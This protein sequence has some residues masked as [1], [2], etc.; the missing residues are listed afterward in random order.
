[1][2]T[3]NNRDN[4]CSRNSITAAAE[5]R[6]NNSRGD[7]SN[8]APGPS[9][10]CGGAPVIVGVPIFLFKAIYRGVSAYQMRRRDVGH[11]QL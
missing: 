6:D 7:A 5:T 10:V 2:Y 1:M 9:M 11:Q 8:T 3:I 4:I